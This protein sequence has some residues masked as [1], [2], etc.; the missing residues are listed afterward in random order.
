M[1]RKL[2]MLKW[3]LASLCISFMLSCNSTPN[4]SDSKIQ[5]KVLNQFKK[6]VKPL[7]LDSRIADKLNYA[8]LRAYAADNQLNYED[9]LA[10]EKQKLKSELNDE[11]EINLQ[12]SKIL[13]ITTEKIE[14]E[15]KKCSCAGEISNPHLKDIEIR[16]TVQHADESEDGIIIKIDYNLKKSEK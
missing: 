4:C 12:A 14:K 10:E 15:I 9:I 13:N 11:V 8:D 5:E 1:Y 6:E 3:V 2:I 7:L 16:Y